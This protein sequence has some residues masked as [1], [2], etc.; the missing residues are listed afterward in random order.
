MTTTGT[1]EDIWSA[2]KKL[3]IAM[4]TTDEDGHL[5]SRPMASIGRPE[6]GKIYFITHT[7]NHIAGRNEGARVNLAYADTDKN[8]YLSIYGI[9]RMTQDR[10]KLEELWSVW[11]EAWLPQGPDSADV[12]LIAVEPIDAK[13]WDASSKLIYAAKMLA[14]AAAQKPPSDGTVKEVRMARR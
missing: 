3:R 4:L 13:L 7:H 8:T 10:A 9:A 12:A 14:A 2:L 6:D 11:S 1:P 5:V